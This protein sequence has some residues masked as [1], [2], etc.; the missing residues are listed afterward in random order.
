VQNQFSDKHD[1]K[2][3]TYS[4]MAGNFLSRER[5]EPHLGFWNLDFGFAQSTERRY[6]MQGGQSKIRN[7]KSQIT[8]TPDT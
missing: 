6:V 1:L 4:I 5:D 2:K 8:L 7:P 3:E